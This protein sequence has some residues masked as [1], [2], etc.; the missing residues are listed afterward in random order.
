M[1]WAN[2]SRYSPSYDYFADTNLVVLRMASTLHERFLEL[3][4]EEIARQLSMI[5]KGEN[6]TDDGTAKAAE[7]AGRVV[8]GGSPTLYFSYGSVVRDDREGNGAPEKHRHAPD[9]TFYLRGAKHPGLVIEL[10]YS[11]HPRKLIRLADHYI[12]GSRR[13][14]RMMI[15]IDVAYPVGQSRRATFSVFV[16]ESVGDTGVR[17][18]RTVIDHVR[19]P[20]PCAA[21]APAKPPR[22]KLPLRAGILDRGWLLARVVPTH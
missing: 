12:L 11:Q 16:P 10:S 14:I 2:Q 4:K 6:S 18:V 21:F 7:F 13:N 17:V 5:A 15:G 3:L 1:T 20:S 22:L 8:R 9:A 19:L